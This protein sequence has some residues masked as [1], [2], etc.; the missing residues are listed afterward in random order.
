MFE[1]YCIA[2]HEFIWL[3]PDGKVSDRDRVTV[4]SKRVMFTIVRSL[5]GFAVVVAIENGCKFNAGYYVSKVLALLSEWLCERGGGNFRNPRVDVK[6]DRLQRASGLS[7]FLA[8]NAIAI[9][10]NPP[11]SPHMAPSDFCRLDHAK[12]LL[13]GESFETGAFCGPSNSGLWPGPFSSR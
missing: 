5:T 8:R 1:F 2:D 11:Y 10:A 9:A 7:Q 4:Q 12:G 13:R 3:P 6:N